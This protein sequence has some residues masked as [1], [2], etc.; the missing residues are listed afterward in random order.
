MTAALPVGG[1]TGLCHE[2][3]ATIDEAAR[4][5]ASQPRTG[6]PVPMLQ[7]RFGLSAMDACKAI[8]AARDI[9]EGRG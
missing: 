7:S 6:S 4:W 9:R 1:T 3:P 2:A 5:L 8:T